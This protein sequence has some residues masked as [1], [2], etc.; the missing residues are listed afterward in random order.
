MRLLLGLLALLCSAA[1]GTAINYIPTAPQ[2]NG[3]HTRS[4]EHVKLFMTGKPD[5][6]YTEIGLIESQQTSM[7]SEG[8]PEL[9][10]SD[11]RAFAGQQGCDALVIF[12]GNDAT[13]VSSSNSNYTSSHTL[14]G[15]RG[16][17]L[18]YTQAQPQSPQQPQPQAELASA[19]SCIPNSTQLCD[20]PGRCRGAQ[21][22][23]EDG[24]SFTLCDCGA[25]T[26][27]PAVPSSAIQAPF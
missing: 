13:V 22:C 17:C 27:S 12:G 21:R 5:R 1:C 8:G 3:M 26:P 14:K 11:M 15:Y 7:L 23:A 18:V 2:P 6:A 9:I 25:E 19:S 10:I 4:P 16:S 20:G 24:R